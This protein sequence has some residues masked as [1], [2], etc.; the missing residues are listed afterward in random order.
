[1]AWTVA[2]EAQRPALGAHATT[3]GGGVD[4]ASS[5][6]LLRDL[7]AAFFQAYLE[8]AS[9][10]RKPQMSL[11][12][13]QAHGCGFVGAA[14]LPALTQLFTTLRPELDAGPEK[15]AAF[16]HFIFFVARDEGQR[17]L[18]STTAVT[19]W[20]FILG[21]GRFQF[22][23]LWLTF[24]KG[25][26]LRRGVS[27]DT[28]CQ[29]LDFA[30]RT[31]NSGNLLQAYDPHGAWPVLVDEFVD[32]LRGDDTT[33]SM[34]QSG[35]SPQEDKWRVTGWG[36]RDRDSGFVG[37]GTYDSADVMDQGG[38]NAGASGTPLVYNGGASGGA[39]LGFGVSDSSTRMVG[40]SLTGV[41][42]VAHTE[43]GGGGAGASTSHSAQHRLHQPTVQVGCK[44]RLSAV[45][46]MDGLATQLERQARVESPAFGQPGSQQQETSS[47]TQFVPITGHAIGGVGGVGTGSNN[48]ITGSPTRKYARVTGRIGTTAAESQAS[49][50][51]SAGA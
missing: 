35:R 11:L 34:N 12:L 49:P 15:F 25:K 22:L 6:N 47:T 14:V 9:E 24:V 48:P 45:L 13:V 8:D 2:L 44:R 50:R 7:L 42:V 31:Q 10:V 39:G 33:Q 32:F 38:S 4:I 3:S 36:T 29:V 20:Q 17:N 51:G 28:W 27:E 23:E 40:G 18:K 46:E 30:I 21:E 1:M 37:V 16:Y 26:D 41:G 19:A 43:W 5:V